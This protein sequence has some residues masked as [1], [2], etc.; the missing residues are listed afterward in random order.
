MHVF[1]GT[2]GQGWKQASFEILQEY[3]SFFVVFEAVRGITYLGD[4][5]VDDV[6]L[7]TG[8]Q[9]S[10]VGM[11]YIIQQYMAERAMLLFFFLSV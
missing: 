8:E 3:D 1:S 4:I 6:Q 2:Q 11:Y 7:L 5:A 10:Q 9:C